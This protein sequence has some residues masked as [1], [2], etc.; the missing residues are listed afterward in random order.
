MLLIEQDGQAISL[1]LDADEAKKVGQYLRPLGKPVGSAT[2]SP[3]ALQDLVD[4]YT[5]EAAAAFKGP[6]AVYVAQQLGVT[7]AT[8]YARLKRAKSL[9]MLA[10]D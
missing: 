4:L 1:P 8:V 5:S 7:D 2:A 6:K 3:E 9:G 10:D